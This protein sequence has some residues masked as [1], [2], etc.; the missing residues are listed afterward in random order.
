MVA[1]TKLPKIT[2]FDVKLKENQNPQFFGNFE[3]N[4]LQKIHN[5]LDKTDYILFVHKVADFL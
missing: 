5:H 2:N 1:K 3:P 4:V